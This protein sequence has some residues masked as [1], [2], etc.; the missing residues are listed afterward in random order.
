MKPYAQKAIVP[1][2]A[3]WTILSERDAMNLFKKFPLLIKNSLINIAMINIEIFWS[4]RAPKNPD[5]DN[6]IL[7]YSGFISILFLL[8]YKYA[9][10]NRE[11]L[12]IA[13]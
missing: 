2:I 3:P 11:K 7:L 5:K 8:I 1:K 6:S 9:I 10:A 13:I 4:V 12:V